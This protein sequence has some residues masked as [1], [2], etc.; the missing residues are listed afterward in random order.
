MTSDKA[1]ENLREQN[2]EGEANNTKMKKEYSRKQF[3]NC[4]ELSRVNSC[5]KYP[6][7]LIFYC[8]RYFKVPCVKKRINVD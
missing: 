5:V 1:D 3:G 4:T 2:L 8:R 6:D 7:S